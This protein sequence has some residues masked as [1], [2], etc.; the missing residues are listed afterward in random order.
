MSEQLS[1]DGQ[2]MWDGSDWV[3]AEQAAAPEPAAPGAPEEV[4][5]AIAMTPDIQMDVAPPVPAAAAPMETQSSDPRYAHNE[6]EVKQR[7]R[8]LFKFGQQYDLYAPG[9]D[10]AV[11]HAHRGFNLA[12]MK[13]D[14]VVYTDHTR[15]EELLRARQTNGFDGWGNF[16]IIDSKTGEHIATYKRHF[17]AGIL[18]RK[19]TVSKPDGTPWFLIQEDSL[20]KS[21]IRRI[22]GGLFAPLLVFLRTNMNFRSLDGTVDFGSFNRKLSLRDRYQLQ[23]A[24]PELDGRLLWITGPL[25]DNCG[26]R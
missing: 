18:Q 19:W 20:A 7:I 26:G 1:E 10:E 6:L 4:A 12:F 25:L 21:L 2:W 22:G 16:E 8:S 3:P 11:G 17:W 13:V 24:T 5:P 14:C 23:R 15:S 9:Q